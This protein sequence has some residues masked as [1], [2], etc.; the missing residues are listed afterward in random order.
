MTIFHG[1][2][3][4]GSRELFAGGKKLFIPR[5]FLF[6][7][8]MAVSGLLP[9]YAHWADLAVAE[10]S[11]GETKAQ[12]TLTLPTGLLAFADDDKNGN[13]SA[14]EVL[15]HQEQIKTELGSR[16]QLKSDGE[17]GELQTLSALNGKALPN[18]RISSKTHSTLLL[19]YAW[20]QKIGNFKMEYSFFVPGVST[21]SCLTTLIR[22]GKVQS[23]VF[24]PEKQEYLLDQ[25]GQPF[26]FKSFVFLGIGHILSG[27]DHLLFVLSLLM[28][29]GSLGYL[30]KVITAFT[31][32]HSITLSLTALG[33]IALPGRFIESGIALSIAYVAAENLFRKDA[34]AL[35][36]SRWVVTFFFGL[37]HG[38]GFADILRE[39]GL[40]RD[41]LLGSLVG[42]NV[43]VELGQLSVVI[44]AFLILLLLKRMPGEIWVRRAIS[45]GA[46][47]AGLIW[48]VQR[49]FL[50]A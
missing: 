3:G 20:P 26:D 16:I 40:P 22:A 31:L 43:G 27:L 50:S 33:F 49:A 15:G 9:A 46:V 25:N 45:A 48:F 2:F 37:I 35:M 5:V 12:M 21:A 28:L 13:L 14:A 47:A 36:K 44:P 38:M 23:V 24:T 17:A 32:A 42:F 6:V 10:V 18:A 41:N 34:S 19:S 29:G 39:M 11:V 1:F 8:A 30:L 4:M 7:L